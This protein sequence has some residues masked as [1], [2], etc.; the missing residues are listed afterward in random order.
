MEKNA[1]DLIPNNWD[2]E[3]CPKNEKKTKI[4]GIFLKLGSIAWNLSFR[5]KFRKIQKLLWKLKK[6]I[7]ITFTNIFGFFSNKHSD[8]RWGGAQE[9]MDSQLLKISV[10]PKK[11]WQIRPRPYKSRLATG[12]VRMLLFFLKICRLRSQ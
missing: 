2:H 12:L 11:K 3:T 4:S 9:I 1:W 7:L 6:S 5:R 10:P 8:N